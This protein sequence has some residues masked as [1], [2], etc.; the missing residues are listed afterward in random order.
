[1]TRQV[2]AIY[3]RNRTVAS[4]IALVV[5]QPDE[6]V[7][8]KLQQM[9]CESWAGFAI[10]LTKTPL[11]V[12][13]G[14]ASRVIYLSPDSTDVLD[15]VPDDA[16]VV[17]G[18]IVDRTVIP[19]L[20]A[21]RAAET[22]VRHFRLPVQEAMRSLGKELASKVVLNVDTAAAAII[23]WRVRRVQVKQATMAN[24]ANYDDVCMYVCVFSH[25]DSP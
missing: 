7:H 25:A 22:G 20:S 17:I 5:C 16:V 2:R 19:G 9:S 18:G 15:D 4:P 24:E 14:D 1:M 13:G 3:A 10:E 6:R 23:L 12:A 8:R 11:D 21:T